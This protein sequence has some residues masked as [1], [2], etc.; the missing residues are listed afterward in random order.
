MIKRAIKALNIYSSKIT[1]FES[2]DYSQTQE[3]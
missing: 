3:T 2:L 1:H